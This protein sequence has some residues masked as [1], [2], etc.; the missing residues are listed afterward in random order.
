M[1]MIAVLAK[2]EEID[3]NHILFALARQAAD[4]DLGLE[5]TLCIFDDM[6][7]FGLQKTFVEQLQVSFGCQPS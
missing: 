2:S 6:K 5:A 4:D 3:I 1:A 7:K